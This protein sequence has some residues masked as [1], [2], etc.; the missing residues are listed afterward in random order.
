MP[1]TFQRQYFLCFVNENVGKA[2]LCK[3]ITG[4]LMEDR[5]EVLSGISA[6]DEII[7]IGCHVSGRR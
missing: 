5:V 4:Q 1:D 2:R 6:Q 7:S 3:I